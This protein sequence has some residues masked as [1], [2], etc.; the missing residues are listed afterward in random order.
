MNRAQ[1]EA[2][3]CRRLRQAEP[4]PFNRVMIG[5]LSPLV[6]KCHDNVDAYVKTNP[7]C[8]AARGWMTYADFIIAV[9]LTAHSVV[10]GPDGVLFDITPLEDEK[11][12]DW[13]RFVRHNGDDKS[14]DAM[15]S[16]NIFIECPQT[17]DGEVS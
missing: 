6:A 10:E 8:A 3:I 14:F 1:Y 5:G 9:G 13:M 15:K 11:Q 12:R 7:T 17:G 4:V 16:L 2:D